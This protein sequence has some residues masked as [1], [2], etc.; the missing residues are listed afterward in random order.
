[1]KHCPFKLYGLLLY[2]ISHWNVRS[3]ENFNRLGK[4]YDLMT[5]WFNYIEFSIQGKGYIKTFHV[6]KSRPVPVNVNWK[7]NWNILTGI[8]SNRKDKWRSFP[9]NSTWNRKD[10]PFPSHFRPVDW[11]SIWWR[12]CYKKSD[13]NDQLR[14]KLMEEGW[15]N[16]WL[17]ANFAFDLRCRGRTYTITCLLIGL[18]MIM[19][20]VYLCYA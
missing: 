10:S 11:T 14:Y 1:M 8:E 7:S 6:P 19:T 4:F 15:S 13:L 12:M 17:I 3:N 20:S 18:R 2:V 9:N 5:L 16:I